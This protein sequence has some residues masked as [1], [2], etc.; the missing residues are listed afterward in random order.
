VH[1]DRRP[2]GEPTHHARVQLDPV[3]LDLHSAAAA[4]AAL[5]PGKLGRDLILRQREAGGDALKD[6]QQA[7]S[8]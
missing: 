1:P 4:I 8:V 6:R 5:S 7:A 3:L 2:D